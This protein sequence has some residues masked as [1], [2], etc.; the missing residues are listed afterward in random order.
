MPGFESSR[1]RLAGLFCSRKFASLDCGHLSGHHLD[2]LFSYFPAN[3]A[4][5]YV[6]A[7]GQVRIVASENIVNVGPAFCT[8]STAFE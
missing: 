2:Q 3:P 1:S 5:G 8:S 4:L 6:D 7:A